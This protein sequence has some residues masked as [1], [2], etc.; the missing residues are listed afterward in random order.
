MPDLVHEKLDVYRTALSLLATIDEILTQVP[1]GRGHLGDQVD[2]AAT[3]IV[4]NI[5]EGAGEYASA[6]K[7][8]F[9][10]MARRSANECAAILDV[11]GARK[12]VAH[13]RISAA[14]ELLVRIVSMLTRM[15]LNGA[16]DKQK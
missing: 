3:S 14:R 16:A 15:V 9:F 13:E 10:R 7:A 12:A 8:R 5:A 2:R 6:E 4:L 11:Y 1:R